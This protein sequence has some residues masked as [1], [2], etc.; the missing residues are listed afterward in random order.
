MQA[1]V[2]LLYR[3]PNV[4]SLYIY[5]INFIV[6]IRIGTYQQINT[7]GGKEIHLDEIIMI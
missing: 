2:G 3:A 5:I 1:R 7:G 6:N 4:L